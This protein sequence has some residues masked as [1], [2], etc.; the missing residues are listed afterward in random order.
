[1]YLSIVPLRGCS[2]RIHF[3]NIKYENEHE[4][5]LVW[6]WLWWL[7]WLWVVCLSA[8]LPALEIPDYLWTCGKICGKVCG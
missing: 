5:E 2:I 6:W 3:I 7:W 1:M 4:H 8:Y